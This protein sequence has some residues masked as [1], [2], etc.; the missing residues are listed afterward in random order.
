MRVNWPPSAVHFNEHG[1]LKVADT[2]EEGWSSGHLRKI[3]RFPSP[4]LDC[5]WITGDFHE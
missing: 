4:C 5:E 3:G 2:P 1:S